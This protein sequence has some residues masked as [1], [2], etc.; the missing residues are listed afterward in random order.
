MAEEPEK[1]LDPRLDRLATWALGTV[2]TIALSV[3][4]YYFQAFTGEMRALN[5]EVSGLTTKVAVIEAQGQ[6]VVDLRREVAGITERLRT[7]E[8]APSTAV[9]LELDALRDRLKRIEAKLDGP[10][11]R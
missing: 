8:L 10:A 2:A 9:R 4:A 11:P 7:L 1:R 3:G 5:K 6:N